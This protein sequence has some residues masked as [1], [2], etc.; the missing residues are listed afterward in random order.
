ME[1]GWINGRNDRYKD[2]SSTVYH[3]QISPEHINERN[4]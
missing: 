3:S 1:E 2:P 4:S